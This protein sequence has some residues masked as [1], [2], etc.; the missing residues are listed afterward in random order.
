MASFSA[1]V[2]PGA[3]ALANLLESKPLKNRRANVSVPWWRPQSY[4]DEPGRGTLSRD[5]GGVPI[6]Q[7][8]HVL[9]LFLSLTGGI[10]E[11]MAYTDTTVIHRMETEDIAAAAIRLNSGGI[12]TLSATTASY[13]GHKEVIEITGESGTARLQARFLEVQFHD[14]KRRQVGEAM[15]WG[16]ANPMALP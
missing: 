15:Q 16:G 7:A 13:P 3:L 4:Y 5:G 14:G 10:S 11:V 8:I 12:G 9:D 1:P 2:R 6:T